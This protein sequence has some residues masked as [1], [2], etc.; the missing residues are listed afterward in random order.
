MAREESDHC[1]RV[2]K[3]MSTIFELH[4]EHGRWAL[5]EI[6]SAF[7]EIRKR[8]ADDPSLPLKANQVSARRASL[9]AVDGG[10]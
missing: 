7:D 5:D 9:H 2:V 1:A 8:A 3:M 4:E 6:T 10:E